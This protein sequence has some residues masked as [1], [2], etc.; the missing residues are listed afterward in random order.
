MWEFEEKCLTIVTDPKMPNAWKAEPYYTALM[1]LC[2]KHLAEDRLVML[3]T[4]EKRYVLLPDGLTYVCTAADKFSWTVNKSTT[5]A[6]SHYYV[7]F[8]FKDETNV[9]IPTGNLGS[10]TFSIAP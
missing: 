1:A 9:P 4:G 3:M 2:E 10:K 6:G 7:Q 5:Q 8:Q